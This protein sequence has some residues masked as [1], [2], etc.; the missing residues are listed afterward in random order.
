MPSG[1][2]TMTDDADVARAGVVQQ[3]E[4]GDGAAAGRQHRID[5]QHE[6]RVEPGGSFA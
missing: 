2:A 3:V 4:R 5:H 1:A 6:A